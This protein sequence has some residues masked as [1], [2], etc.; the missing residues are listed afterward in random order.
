MRSMRYH[1]DC[2]PQPTA[3]LPGARRC[4]RRWV[5]QPPS[6]Q[7]K[8]N[9]ASPF[10][11][12]RDCPSARRVNLCPAIWNR[13]SGSRLSLRA[14]SARYDG[15]LPEPIGRQRASTR[16][17]APIWRPGRHFRPS[18]VAQAR[19][20]RARCINPAARNLTRAQSSHPVASPAANAVATHRTGIFLPLP[21]RFQCPSRANR[22]PTRTHRE[23]RRNL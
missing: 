15:S 3:M 8:K 21:H 6:N 9:L 11:G 7:R 16:R 14:P 5:T 12:S 17:D 2:R 19:F 20:R 1:T 22:S 18:S 4:R 10:T 23:S 13:F